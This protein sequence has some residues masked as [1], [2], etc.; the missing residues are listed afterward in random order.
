[1]TDVLS[2]WQQSVP[3]P[4]FARE[5]INLAERGSVPKYCDVYSCVL[6]ALIKRSNSQVQSFCVNEHYL[7]HLCIKLVGTLW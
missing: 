1:M 4:L 7:L 3:K 2:L 5:I 6:S